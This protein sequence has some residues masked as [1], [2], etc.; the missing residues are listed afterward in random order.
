MNFFSLSLPVS[1]IDN[2]AIIDALLLCFLLDLF[3]FIYE[4]TA[5]NSMGKKIEKQQH[6]IKELRNQ[7]E[8][9]K[10]K[11]MTTVFVEFR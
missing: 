2:A 4:Q 11:G 9:V 10:E 8:K 3:R 7:A 5:T 6:K 1:A